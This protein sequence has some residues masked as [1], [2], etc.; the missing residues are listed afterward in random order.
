MWSNTR[1]SFMAEVGRGM[2]AAGVGS[3]LACDLGLGAVPV[4]DAPERL[5]FG[6]LESLVSFMQETSIDHLQRAVVEKL[7]AG[8]SLQ[9]LVAAA[10]LANV[11]T[12]GGQDYDGYHT[13][14]ALSPALA[15]AR[16]LP[17]SSA[18]LPVLKVLYR[19]THRIQAQGG[20]QREKLHPVTAEPSP[21]AAQAG[22]W[23]Q[24]A[25]RSGD[26]DR[27]ERCFATL[28]KDSVGEAYNHLQFSIQDEVDVHRVV[29]A[30]RAWSMLDVC[31]PAYAHALSASR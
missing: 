25:T 8:T 5:E 20:S 18:A 12:F 31:G 14:M 26:M 7:A 30:W 23:L 29:L 1:R 4:D 24:A 2:L 10:A 13:F 27:A 28:T 3:T 6:Q 9:T 16:Q 21:T 22:P 17:G 11:R 19:N 15:M